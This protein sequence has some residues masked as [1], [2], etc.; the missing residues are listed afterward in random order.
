MEATK[1][2]T[3]CNT[4]KQ[5]TEFNKQK[6]NLDGLM[7]MCR[8]CSIHKKTMYYRTARGLIVKIYRSQVS[9]CKKKNRPLPSYTLEELQE[10]ILSNKEFTALYTNWQISGYNKMLTPSIDRLENDK[11]YEFSNLQLV[12]WR[13]NK[14]NGHKDMRAGKIIHGARPHKKVIQYTT[15]M[16][17]I[18][19]FVS[20]REAERTTGIS[21]QAISKVCKKVK[22]YNSAGGY[23]WRYKNER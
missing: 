6:S 7:Y 11:Y 14:L 2:C 22:S 21:H 15:D 8:K 1:I 19:E 18:Q 16:Q 9:R 5:L 17:L 4:E 13:Q 20:T 23:I 10:W 12:T 3:S